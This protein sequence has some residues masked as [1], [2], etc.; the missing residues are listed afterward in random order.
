MTITVLKIPIEQS[1]KERL[2]ELAKNTG[3]SE[4]EIAAE[5]IHGMLELNDE[6][7]EGIKEALAEVER[8]EIVPHEALEEWVASWGTDKELPRPTPIRK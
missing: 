5:A 7:V 1:D 4:E 8:G 6:Q 3:R 2:A